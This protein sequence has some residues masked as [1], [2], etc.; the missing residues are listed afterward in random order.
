M[1]A[2]VGTVDMVRLSSMLI[3]VVKPTIKE[4]YASKAKALMDEWQGNC[5]QQTAIIVANIMSTS[6]DKLGYT[7]KAFHGDF[8][9]LFQG[10]QVEYNHCWVY[11]ESNYDS[12]ESILIDVGRTTKQCVVMHRNFNS[13]D[14]RIKGYENQHLIKFQEIDYKASLNLVEYFTQEKGNVAY[15][16]I[17][18]QINNQKLLKNDTP[19]NTI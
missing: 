6:I 8:I 14:K 11:C 7:T 4:Y 12:E 19:K 15:K 9:D 16:A 3:D 17:L 13:Y 5:C 18:K 2:T 10:N 1:V